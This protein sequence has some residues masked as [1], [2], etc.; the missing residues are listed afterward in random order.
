MLNLIQML[1]LIATRGV[2]AVVRESFR[3]VQTDT[4]L[5]GFLLSWFCAAGD[6]MITLG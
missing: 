2:S 6:K 1:F 4:E 5:G 3:L